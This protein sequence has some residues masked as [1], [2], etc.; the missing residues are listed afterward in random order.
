VPVEFNIPLILAV[1]VAVL[2]L[3]MA[4]LVLPAYI[5][6]RKSSPLAAIKFD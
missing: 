4:I 2:V 6:A 3:C 1:N 5:V